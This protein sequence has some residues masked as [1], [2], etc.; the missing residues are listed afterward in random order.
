[1]ELEQAL[2]SYT[3]PGNIRELEHE[4]QTSLALAP[5]GSALS[6]EGFG[7]LLRRHAALVKVHPKEK[8]SPALPEG[9]QSLSS[10]E[11]ALVEHHL[12]TAGGN[13]SQA[14]K[15]LGLSREGLRKMMKRLGLR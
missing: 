12:Q 5:M 13:R 8:E 2:R 15:S 6:L 9:L 14:A 10:Q 7:P 1:M 11:R 3:W 4:A